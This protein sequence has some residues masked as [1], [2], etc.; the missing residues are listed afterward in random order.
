MLLMRMA[1]WGAVAILPVFA[2]HGPIRDRVDHGDGT[3]GSGNWSGYAVT[4]TAFTSVRGSWVVPA[5]TCSSGYQFSAFWVGIDGFNSSTVE[6][7]GTSSD[8]SGSTP[9]YYAWYE[10]YPNPS[11]IISMKVTPG[12]RIGAS[13][14][15]SGGEF[16][17][18]IKDET[19]GKAFRTSATVSGATRSSAE[20]IAEA[21]YYNGILPLADFGTALF[22]LDST[23]VAGTNVAT[24]STTSG[25]IGV[26][27]SGS[28]YAITM[29]K[30]SVTE[31][32]PS[33]L[34]SDGSS[35]S[36]AWAHR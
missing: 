30:N 34:S 19:T 5:V 8:C 4:G 3:T 31:A 10:F 29:E 12:D 33:A 9:V 11:Y 18:T 35:F 32:V 2:Q 24:D 16:T 1:A 20:W 28:I 15:Y 22:G 13:V 26:F 6:Q 36:V 7:T 23:G 21:P 25:R 17:V 14:V 27:P